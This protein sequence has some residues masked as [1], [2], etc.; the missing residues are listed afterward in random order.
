MVF[1]KV[2]I[3]SSPGITFYGMYGP[4]QQSDIMSDLAFVTNKFDNSG[5]R[6]ISEPQVLKEKSHLCWIH[7]LK[8]L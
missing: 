2:Y 7:W 4:A 5:L 3:F 1:Y 6:H 8:Y